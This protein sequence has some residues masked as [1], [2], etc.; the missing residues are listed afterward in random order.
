MDRQFRNPQAVVE[1]HK[2]GHGYAYFTRQNLDIT[3]I[4]HIDY[5]GEFADREVK[6]RFFKAG[7]H[8]F[9]IPMKT[10]RFIRSKRPDIVLVEGMIFPHWVILLRI[11]LNN[12]TKIILQHHGERPGNPITLLLQRIANRY[13]EKYLFTATGNA[14][15]WILNGAIEKKKCVEVLEAS[16]FFKSK[17]KIQCKRM[18]RLPEGTIFLWVGRLSA[19]K[20]PLTIL[21]GFG[22]YCASRTDSHLYL[23]YQ[24]EDLIIQARDMVA[25]NPS[26]RDR[27]HFVGKVEHKALESWFSAADY[28][29]AGSHKEGSGYALLEAL[30]CG[31]IPVVSDIPP[32]RKIVG[33]NGFH[34][35]TGDASSLAET[36]NRLGDSNMEQLHQR[37]ADHFDKM[38]SFQKIAEDI[39]KVCSDLSG[40]E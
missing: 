26:L 21:S 36:L 34:F 23:I 29:L 24:E 25:N 12:R 5:E 20:D 27:V 28:Y 38:L 37:I 18:L 14:E 11:I 22:L 32:F 16:T 31:C 15:E 7:Q 2:P 40:R 39:Y 8:F 10:M 4:E 35:K 30:A 13:I 6:Y 19:G 1:M 33:G 9:H 3:I 17:D